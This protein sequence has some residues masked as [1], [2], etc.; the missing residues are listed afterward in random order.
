MGTRADI[1]QQD[2]DVPPDR[3]IAVDQKT[4]AAL[5]SM[6]EKTFRKWRD[7]GLVPFVSLGSMTRYPVQA[8]IA[9]LGSEG[10][11]AVKP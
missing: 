1:E 10:M 3:R 4:M 9:A 7:A 11:K 8:T 6:D 5:L 2:V